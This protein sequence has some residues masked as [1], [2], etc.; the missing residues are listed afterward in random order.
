[1]CSNFQPIKNHHSNWVKQHFDCELPAEQW[2]EE[3]YPTYPAPFIYLK[4]GKP[5]CELAQFGLVP[6]W[7]TDKKK[8]G[9]K[10]ITPGLKLFTKNQ[11]TGQPG[12]IGDL[13]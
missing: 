4:D 7:A 12:K 3:I 10:P 6:H 9:L 11:A 1:M 13:G 5:H 8:F 2:R